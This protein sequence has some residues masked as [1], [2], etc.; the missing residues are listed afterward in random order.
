MTLDQKIALAS[1]VGSAL[2]GLCALAVVIFMYFQYSGEREERRFQKAA[3]EWTLKIRRSLI[4][5]Q[6]ILRGT[7]TAAADI[8]EG[9]IEFGYW[10]VEKGFLEQVRV[11]QRG[12]MK[13]RL[14]DPIV[15]R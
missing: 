12:Q 5:S 8:P 3:R 11:G 9:E 2:A 14:P 10:A 7:G 15:P 4:E 13:L 6:Q 1:A